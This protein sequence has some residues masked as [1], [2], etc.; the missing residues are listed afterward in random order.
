MITTIILT[1]NSQEKIEEV[2]KSVLKLDGEILVLDDE[3][4]DDTVKIAKK[5]GSRVEKQTGKGYA[6]K[7]NLG[8]KLAKQDW[9]FYLDSDELL[10][11][12]LAKEIKEIAKGNKH[13]VYAVPRKNIILGKAMIHG[14]WYPDYVE[15]LFKKD[16]LEK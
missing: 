3:S 14:G 1:K 4:T 2:I 6:D 11:P 15:R 8:L 5:L 7:R 13:S 9:I 16:S 10:T 12:E